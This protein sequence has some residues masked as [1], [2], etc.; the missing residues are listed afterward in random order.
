MKRLVKMCFFVLIFAGLGLFNIGGCGSSG[1]GGGG[2]GCCVVGPDACVD[3]TNQAECDLLEGVLDKGV[4]CSAIPECGVVPPPTNPPPTNPPPTNP[5]PVLSCEDI[6]NALCERT[7]ECDQEITVELCFSALEFL[8]DA[9]GLACE[10]I[11]NLSNAQDCV[12]DLDN[13]DCQELD[14]APPAS[15]SPE[16]VCDI[17]ET[18]NDC[19][20]S[21]LCFECFEDCTGAVDRC[22][23]VFFSRCEDGLF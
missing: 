18:D 10:E 15:C 16:G 21:Q 3:G 7:E 5:P 13:F 23:S 11:F 20:E 1:G 12:A 6:E 17:C 2:E 8:K 19:D 14:I 4:M 9:S 22:S